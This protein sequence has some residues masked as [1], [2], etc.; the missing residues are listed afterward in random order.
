MVQFERAHTI[1]ALTAL[2]IMLFMACFVTSVEVFVMWQKKGNPL[3][4]SGEPFIS[5]TNREGHN[6]SDLAVVGFEE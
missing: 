2:L 6:D 5:H 4:S 1:H 3:H